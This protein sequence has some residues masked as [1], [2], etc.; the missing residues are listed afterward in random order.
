M[1]KIKIVVPVSLSDVGLLEGW[2]N[3]FRALGGANHPVEF[4]PTPVVKAVATEAARALRDFCPSVTVHSTDKDFKG[5][6]PK[7]CNAHYGHVMRSLALR[8][9]DLPWLWNELDMLSVVPDAYDRISNEYVL[10]GGRGA[11]GVIMPTIKIFNKGKPDQRVHVDQADLYMVGV[12]VYDPY[13]YSDLGGISDQLWNMEDP[14]D[15][16]LRHYTKKAWRSTDLITTMSR[17]IN[18]RVVDDEI[19]CDDA[20]GKENYELRAGIVPHGTVLHHGCKD[21]SLARLILE[22]IGRPWQTFADMM[23]NVVIPK[24]E[25]PKPVEPPKQLPPQEQLPTPQSTEQSDPMLAA[26]FAQQKAQH[27]EAETPHPKQEPVAVTASITPSPTLEQFKTEIQQAQ[28]PMRVVNFA[29]K[30]GTTED[31]LKSLAKKPGS[32]IKVLP[33]GWA[34]IGP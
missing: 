33:G 32:G 27:P 29:Q 30:L 8:G 13:Y 2:V 23:L 15:V 3:V 18:Y 26:M 31:H 7:A 1:N 10:T 11:M 21:E 20:P 12:G 34:K 16:V 14:F 19:V 9:N 17:T 6:W 4:H 28:K 22:T 24:P 5:G 25:L